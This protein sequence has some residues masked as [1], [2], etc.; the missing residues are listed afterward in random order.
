[1][2]VFLPDL[3]T[4]TEIVNNKNI[5]IMSTNSACQTKFGVPDFMKSAS[6]KITKVDLPGFHRFQQRIFHNYCLVIMSFKKEEIH[7]I[8][9]TTVF[10]MISQFSPIK[11]MEEGEEAFDNDILEEIWTNSDQLKDDIETI[12]VSDIKNIWDLSFL[13]LDLYQ[14]Y[15][16][17]DNIFVSEWNSPPKHLKN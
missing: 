13:L 10:Q 8:P 11:E 15:N 1:M 9:W 3:L 17:P 7:Y 12:D 4:L 14:R 6:A 2:K 5:N 16:E